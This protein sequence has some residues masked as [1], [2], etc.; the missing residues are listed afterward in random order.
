MI[1]DHDYKFI[2]GDLNFRID[3][4][5]EAVRREVKRKNY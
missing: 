3:M 5:D 1:H 2:L 4:S